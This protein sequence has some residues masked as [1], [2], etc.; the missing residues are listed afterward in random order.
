MKPEIEPS[1]LRARRFHRSSIGNIFEHSE[2]I[3]ERAF[4]R[5]LGPAHDTA[6]GLHAVMCQVVPLPPA[7]TNAS[8]CSTPTPTSPASSPPPSASPKPRAPNRPRPASTRSPTPN[9]PQFT[10]L[11]DAYVEKFGFPF[12]IAVRDN[13]KAQILAA[14]ETRLAN[15]RD[16][17]FTTA[18]KQVERIAELRLK[19]I[20][21]G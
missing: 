12:I 13:T 7:K 18:C 14:F 3:A 8:A 6:T 9:A 21:P 17:E 20:L 5:E 16:T 4:K 15:D 19:Q 10:E 11:N 1:T 2:W